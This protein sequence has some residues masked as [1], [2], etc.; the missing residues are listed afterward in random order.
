VCNACQQANIHQLPYPKS[1]SVSTIPLELVFSDVWGPAPESVGR[2]QYY[3]SFI[4]DLNK[5]TWIYPLK[6][7][8]EVFQKFKEFQA[9]VECLFDCKIV[10]MQTDWGGEYQRLNSIVHQ[11]SCSHA[12]QQNGSA[13]RKHR[14][15]V[16]I[17]LVL[18]AQ[19]SIPLKFWDEAFLATVY[20][21]NRMPSKT[22]HSTPLEHLFKKPDYSSLR[23][24]DCACWP[25]LH[26]YTTR[27]LQFRSK[28][29]VFLGFSDMHKGFKCLKVSSRQV[30]ISRDVIF[31]ENIFPRASLHS[32]AGAHLRSEI[33]NLSSDLFP[34]FSS[35]G[36]VQLGNNMTNDLANTTNDLVGKFY[37]GTNFFSSQSGA[38]DTNSGRWRWTR[39]RSSLWF[40]HTGVWCNLAR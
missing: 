33:V 38:C 32:N 23:T 34:T 27:K 12:H 3:V 21:I 5:Y 1:T 11:L 2:K 29:C 13:E 35:L 39:G 14:H 28:Q 6:Y 30:Y 15:I 7:K 37:P 17:G 26:P 18:L 36:G 16:E 10:A 24:F 40:G 19:A 4:D 25:N 9:Q 22:I 8:S 20:L 31:D